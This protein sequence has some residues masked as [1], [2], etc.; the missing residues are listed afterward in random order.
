MK[1]PGITGPIVIFSV[2]EAAVVIGVVIYSVF[3]K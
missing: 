1:K 3:F 2:L